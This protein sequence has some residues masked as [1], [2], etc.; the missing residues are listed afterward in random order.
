LTVDFKRRDKNHLTF[1]VGIHRCLGSNFARMQL[2]I[3]LEEWLTRI[4]EFAIAPGGHTIFQSGR[5][6]TVLELPLVW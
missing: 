2:N 5:A 3:L 4:P 1:G 6:N